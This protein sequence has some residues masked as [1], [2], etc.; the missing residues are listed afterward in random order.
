MEID[1]RVELAHRRPA[2]RLD[3]SPVPGAAIRDVQVDRRPYRPGPKG[4]DYFTMNPRIRAI[5]LLDEDKPIA[6][7]QLDIANRDLQV[8]K[9]PEPHAHVR[10][11][12][13]DLVPGTRPA[14]REACVAEIE[15]W[16]TLPAGVSARKLQPT[17]EVALPPTEDWSNPPLDPDTYCTRISTS[18]RGTTTSQSPSTK[19]RATPA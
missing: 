8:V 16:G 17:V 18:R 3:R 14:W 5:T 6:S 10:V 12:I 11:R 15:A 9:L 13:D 1:H 4:E 2:R 19:P 7:A